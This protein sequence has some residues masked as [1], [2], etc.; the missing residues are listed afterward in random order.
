VTLG[1]SPERADIAARPVTAEAEA[2]PKLGFLGIGWIGRQ[3]MEAIAADRHAHVVAIADAAEGVMKDALAVAPQARA[4][5][6]L[7]EL[8]EM[9]LDGIVIATPSSLHAEQAQAALSRG[10]AVFCQKPLARTEAETAGV[11]AAARSANRLLGVDFSY[12]HTE[13]MRRIREL[14]AAG[15]LGEIYALDLVFHNAYG[16]DKP[17]FRDVAL[18]GGG[19]VIDL[20][21]HLVDLA[22]WTLDFPRVTH[23]RSRLYAQGRALSTNPRV[24]EDYA[25][26]ELGLATGAVARIACSWNLSAGCDAVI[27]ATFHGSR[28]AASMRNVNGSF[29]DFV[30]ERYRG[31]CRTTLVEPPDAWGGRAGVVWAR[32]LACRER[33]DREIEHASEVAGVIDRIYGR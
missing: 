2:R 28:G 27:E 12:R 18:S 7:G 5:Q 31:T 30:A 19:C 24:V 13:A 21:I 3:R 33:F 17:W 32:R 9:G 11:I 29:Y 22:L 20:G 25:V 4:A 6:G 23:V 1:L 26:A 16:P 10:I 8:L 15:E 14:V